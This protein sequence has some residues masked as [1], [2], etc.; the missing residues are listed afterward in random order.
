MTPRWSGNL[1]HDFLAL[2][3]ALAAFGQIT[4]AAVVRDAWFGPTAKGASSTA[5]GM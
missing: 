3:S 1:S 2:D 5:R 4:A